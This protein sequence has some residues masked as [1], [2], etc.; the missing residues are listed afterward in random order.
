MMRRRLACLTALL[1]LTLAL[2]EVA[3]AADPGAVLTELRRGKGA[4]LVK[5]AGEDRWKAAKPLMS[6]RP[7]DQVR[8]EGDARAVLVLA[9]GGTRTVTADS[10]PFAVSSPTAGGRPDTVKAAVTNAARF[11][12]GKQTEPTFVRLTSRSVPPPFMILSPRDTRILPAPVS[13]VW[14]GSDSLRYSVEVIGPRGPVWSASDLAREPLTYPSSAPPLRPGTRYEWVLTPR[15]Y[16]PVRAHFEI[17]SAE[18]AARVQSALA[19][20]E[21]REVAGY[22]RSTVTLLRAGLLANEGL[23]QEALDEILDNMRAHKDEPTLQFVL[24]QLY[25]QMGLRHLAT[26]AFARARELGGGDQ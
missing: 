23:Y 3:R 8:A 13:F 20:F 22:P 4:V 14:A 12:A 5:L 25:E 17:V 10:S 26:Q 15:G 6:L 2:V 21:S 18:D 1:V 19:L 24:G 7:G 16:P 11:L 9:G